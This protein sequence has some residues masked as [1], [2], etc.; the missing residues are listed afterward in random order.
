M[1][2]DVSVCWHPDEAGT[3]GR[4][5]AGDLKVSGQTPG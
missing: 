5:L 4:Q 1:L 2:A 3:A